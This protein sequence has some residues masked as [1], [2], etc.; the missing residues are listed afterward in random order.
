MKNGNILLMNMLFFSCSAVIGMIS[1]QSYSPTAQSRSTSDLESSEV[2]IDNSPEQSQNIHAAPAQT[3]APTP[4]LPIR[5]S[6]R[7]I[8]PITITIGLGLAAC[9]YG[10][11]ALESKIA[12]SLSFKFHSLPIQPHFMNSYDP[13]LQYNA[14]DT[15]SGTNE[16]TEFIALQA[17]PIDWTSNEQKLHRLLSKKSLH[18]FKR[19]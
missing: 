2:H 9:G 6:W 7:K 16:H 8:V 15:S 11:Y 13:S 18:R 5:Y 4:V 10:I 3:I 1:P 14:H 12:E 17:L 19:Q